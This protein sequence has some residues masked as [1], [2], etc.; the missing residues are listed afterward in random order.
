MVVV[1]KLKSPAPSPSTRE[2]CEKRRAQKFIRPEPRLIRRHTYPHR[3]I[4]TVTFWLDGRMSQ[5]IQ[6]MVIGP[7]LRICSELPRVW[8]IDPNTRYLTAGSLALVPFDS[9]AEGG[10]FLKVGIR[11][12]GLCVKRPL[13]PRALDFRTFNLLSTGVAG[14][15][16]KLPNIKFPNSSDAVRELT[17]WQHWVA[18]TSNVPA[19]SDSRRSP[20]DVCSLLP[21]ELPR[22]V[23]VEMW[24][25]SSLPYDVYV[26]FSAEDSRKVVDDE[27]IR[28]TDLQAELGALSSQMTNGTL[29]L[30]SEL[31]KDTVQLRSETANDVL[32]LSSQLCLTYE[33]IHKQQTSLS[34]HLESMSQHLGSL[35]RHLESIVSELRQQ[36]SPIHAGTLSSASSRS[37]GLAG[38]VAPLR[39]DAAEAVVG[40]APFDVPAPTSPKSS[41]P[42]VV[43]GTDNTSTNTIAISDETTNVENPRK[44]AKGTTKSRVAVP[45]SSLSVQNT[46][47]PVLNLIQPAVTEEVVATTKN[48][49][50]DVKQRGK[51][52][53]KKSKQT[54]VEPAANPE[55]DFFLDLD[56]VEH[57]DAPSG[58]SLAA[59]NVSLQVPISSTP[60]PMDVEPAEDMV[61]E[62][63][64]TLKSTDISATATRK[65][66]VRTAKPYKPSKLERSF[67][68]TPI[69]A[70][71]HATI[72]KRLREQDVK[73][74]ADAV[75]ALEEEFS[76]ERKR[77]RKR[78][79]A[80]A[81]T[82]INKTLQNQ[83]PLQSSPSS[84][85]NVEN[86]KDTDDVSGSNGSSSSN[87][88]PGSEKDS[89]VRPV[90]SPGF[91][92]G[93][94]GVRIPNRIV[95]PSRA[96]S[97]PN[98]LCILPTQ[99][100]RM[101][102]PGTEAPT[103]V[104]KSGGVSMVH[105]EQSTADGTKNKQ[106]VSPIPIA[107]LMEPPKNT[108]LGPKKSIVSTP[109][110]PRTSAFLN[111]SGPRSSGGFPVKNFV[112]IDDSSIR[113]DSYLDAFDKEFN[114]PSLSLKANR[115]TFL[116]SRRPIVD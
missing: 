55:N 28:L 76:P 112:A 67:G 72:K 4:P 78:Q 73:E 42:R 104:K 58:V 90:C 82:P 7:G 16:L 3:Q 17:K 97:G 84:P 19:T 114:R 43:A 52:K 25:R 40:V 71:G 27:K 110:M 2:G 92:I 5:D 68:A 96:T 95:F 37:S 63:T 113:L 34:Q 48:N 50:D 6:S 101:D 31:A 22:E 18:V 41:L 115:A 109:M 1:E 8:Q 23:S 105:R 65:S 88:M 91:I 12:C 98:E 93:A 74:A 79:S 47:V 85:L 35:S 24:N 14:G 80:R 38:P 102:G 20:E 75:D 30:R 111:P 59:Q 57:D 21:F 33:M 10:R 86:E 9:S 29:N 66:R 94:S 49:T 99:M 81:S 54:D 39:P 36:R 70:V 108:T 62:E 116:Q 26:A 60:I 77:A 44:K 45:S 103:I 32:K 46:S 64:T 13:E 53:T 87:V 61:V 106:I 51:K 100:R 15:T 89:S 56:S 83:T 69:P 11:I 107:A